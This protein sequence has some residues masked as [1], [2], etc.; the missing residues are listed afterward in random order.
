MSDRRADERTG[1]HYG[2]YG[3]A[4]AATGQ[5]DAG[6]CW[7]CQIAELKE[8][9][10]Q[11][12]N[13]IPRKWRDKPEVFSAEFSRMAD[14]IAELKDDLQK[15]QEEIDRYDA[16]ADR[17]RKSEKFFAGRCGDAEL[18]IAELEAKQLVINVQSVEMDFGGKGVIV[19]PNDIATLETMCIQRDK[20]IAE[21][22]A[23]LQAERAVNAA[24]LRDRK[25]LEAELEEAYSQ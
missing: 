22:E 17:L 18:R 1:E 15:Y 5:L 12:R 20:R 9:M 8:E 2:P 10:R 25:E 24:Q 14:R 21:L 19:H 11:Y 7:K 23:Q 4:C 3:T 13:S 6:F 16:E